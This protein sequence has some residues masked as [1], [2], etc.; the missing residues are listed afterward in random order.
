MD[1]IS[2]EP[3]RLR[4]EASRLQRELVNV[5]VTNY[6]VLV[7][8]YE[9]QG[10]VLSH[11]Q[12]SASLASGPHLGS[13]L[14][15][16]RSDTSKLVDE[17]PLWR[18]HRQETAAA[19]AAYPKLAELLDAPLT[20]DQCIRCD[21]FHEAILVV[22]HVR[23]IATQLS[24]TT[25]PAQP[26]ADTATTTVATTKWTASV[27]MQSIVDDCLSTVERLAASLL[28][29]RLAAPSTSLP[30]ALRLIQFL[31]QI[32]ADSDGDLAS[33]V[34]A[35]RREFVAAQEAE[36]LASAP[37]AGSF[38]AR[39]LGIYKVHCADTLSTIRAC[40]AMPATSSTTAGPSTNVEALCT[41]WANQQAS[42]LVDLFEEHLPKVTTGS[43]FAQLIE[44]INSLSQP[45]A[46]LGIDVSAV[47]AAL[48]QPRIG[49][50]FHA[51]LTGTLTT[52]DVALAAHRWRRVARVMSSGEGKS[53]SQ[54]GATTEAAALTPPVGLLPLLPLAYVVNGVATACNELRKCA[55]VGVWPAARVSTLLLMSGIVQRLE[56][57]RTECGFEGEEEQAAAEE[58][59]DA[60]FLECL[61]F[62]AHC[63]DRVFSS[64]AAGGPTD[65]I[66]TD[67]RDAVLALASR[68]HTPPRLP[69]TR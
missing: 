37:T 28:I 56:R 26:G 53:P 47:L 55:L 22:D 32:G 43:D 58:F 61:P 46:R 67:L 31:K 9:S 54:P 45:A 5:A 64:V 24:A 59:R 2:G 4:G 34:L 65:A 29:P 13:L 30:T 42:H 68:W 19:V 44:H 20:L 18:R 11:F 69:A 8:A 15:S 6:P 21:M 62:V 17:G 63:V 3:H 35:I 51:Q 12:R 57:L 10:R 60:C 38:L 23:G 25:A 40:F 66:R 16:L 14:T 27:V 41:G 33:L 7:A 48:I 39:C 52:F 50:W 1:S 49:C 36:A